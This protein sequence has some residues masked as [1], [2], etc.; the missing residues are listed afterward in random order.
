MISGN[1]SGIGVVGGP[2]QFTHNVV[3]ANNGF[4][5][6]FFD[7]LEILQGQNLVKLNDIISNGGSGIEVN[8]TTVPVVIT[9]NNIYGNGAIDGSNCGISVQQNS[10]SAINNYWGTPQG[11]ASIPPTR[12]ASRHCVMARYRTMMPA[13][14]SPKRLP[15]SRLVCCVTA[16]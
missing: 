10:A 14:R 15:P 9:Q 16:G 7:K 8:R 2:F 12:W 6:S 3:T 13:C 11:P 5:F 1:G 4:G